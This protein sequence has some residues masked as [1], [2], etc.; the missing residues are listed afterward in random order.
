MMPRPEPAVRDPERATLED[1]DALNR[2]F[3]ESFTD[4]YYRDG[5][6]GVR[7]PPLSRDVW[8]YAIEDA[9]EGALIWRDVEGQLVAFNMVHR[10]GAEGWMGP[11]CVRPSL[12]G[13]GL[14]RR[15]VGAGIAWLRRKGATVIGLETMPRTVDNIGFYSRL[16][17]VPGHL[18]VTLQKDLE[19]SLVPAVE[20]ERLSRAGAR[21][22]EHLRA[23]AAL[24]DRLAPG[25]DYTR[26]MDLTEELRLGDTTLLLRGAEVA[27]FAMWQTAPLA[28]GRAADE[29]RVLKVVAGDVRTF[30][31]VLAAVERFAIERGGLTRI[32]VRCPSACADAYAALIEDAYRVQWTDLR[33]TLAGAAE[34]RS[35]EGVVISNWEI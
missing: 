8:R 21:R 1:I 6:T 19:R 2:L 3:T 20:G 12:Q 31:E 23:C 16:G 30:R 34:Q 13:G 18:T 26:E 14:G 5:M 32:G 28:Q 27:G 25:V 17:F 10:S 9:G 24:T 4:R 7:V 33:M 29:I 22:A 11:L 35:D 15:I